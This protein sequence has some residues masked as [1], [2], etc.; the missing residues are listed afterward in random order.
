MKKDET[1]NL[2]VVFGK[3]LCFDDETCVKVF[4]TLTLPTS[5]SSTGGVTV[6][7]TG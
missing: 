7:D 2:E 6:F 5:V 1:H 3:E 4:Q